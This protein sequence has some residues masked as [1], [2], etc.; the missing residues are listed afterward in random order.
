MSQKEHL[1]LPWA[2]DS[3]LP[4]NARSV[5]LRTA[6]GLAISANTTGPHDVNRDRDIDNFV[7][8]ACNAHHDLVAALE[9]IA[10][11]V[12]DCEPEDG[13]DGPTIAFDCSAHVARAAL[14]KAKG[15]DNA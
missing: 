13:F 11:R 4:P 1:Y 7:P 9:R 10:D 3:E 8:V 5:I 2:V 6:G 12:C 15:Y 14:A